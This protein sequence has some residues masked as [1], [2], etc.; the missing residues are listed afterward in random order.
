MYIASQIYYEAED[1]SPIS[2]VG[3]TA[4]EAVQNLIAGIE[5]D[6]FDYYDTERPFF[7]CFPPEMYVHFVGK[8]GSAAHQITIEFK[9]KDEYKEYCRNKEA[10]SNL[11]KALL[12]GVLTKEEYEAKAAKISNEPFVPVWTWR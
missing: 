4:E 8:S 7:E 2:Y 1:S 6:H 12:S 3:N 11:N 5:R 9:N 10:K